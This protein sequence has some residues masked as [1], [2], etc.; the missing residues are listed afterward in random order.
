MVPISR[1]QGDL[2]RD[3]R[4]RHIHLESRRAQEPAWGRDLDGPG[5]LLVEVK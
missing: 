2:A 4:A 5:V 1:P 3:D